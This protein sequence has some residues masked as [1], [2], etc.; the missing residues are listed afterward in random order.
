VFLCEGGGGGGVNPLVL[1]RTAT[2]AP[3]WLALNRD[4]PCAPCLRP[5]SPPVHHLLR[6]WECPAG[7]YPLT[8][9]SLRLFQH[10]T[11]DMLKNAVCTDFHACFA[12]FDV[13]GDGTISHE[14]FDQA[15]R[16]AGFQI[17]DVA[18]A[19]LIRRLD[20]DGDG[21]IEYHEFVRFSQSQQEV[22]IWDWGP[23]CA[24]AKR[25]LVYLQRVSRSFRARGYPAKQPRTD[26]RSAHRT[27]CSAGRGSG[28]VQG[29][30]GVDPRPPPSSR[31]PSMAYTV[32]V[33]KLRSVVGCAVSSPLQPCPR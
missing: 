1:S 5:P 4:G 26:L 25:C 19:Q 8:L 3:P 14:E 20:A 31:N 10:L 11:E 27:C 6:N 17:S 32:C 15:L 22:R 33:A 9:A 21:V 12:K 2:L 30:G 28:S 16:R 24:R 18:L 29:T 13:N 7:V 23:I